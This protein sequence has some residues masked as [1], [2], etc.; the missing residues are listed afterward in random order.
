MR[1]CPPPASR[2]EPRR[3]KGHDI[4]LIFFVRLFGAAIG[5]AAGAAGGALS[6]TGVDD[7]FMKRLGEELQPWR[8]SP[9]PADPKGVRRQGAAP[10][11]GARH[12]HPDVAQQ[13]GRTAAPK[14]LDAART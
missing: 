13:R 5:A 2:L 9:D 8:G 14:A 1:T 3:V 7:D 6:N 10:D 4:E 12:R 11:P